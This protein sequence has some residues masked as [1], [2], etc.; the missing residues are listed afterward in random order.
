MYSTSVKYFGHVKRVKYVIHVFQRHA[1]MIPY[2]VKQCMSYPM[3]WCYAMR[4]RR[5]DVTSC[6][7]NVISE[8]DLECSARLSQGPR[9]VT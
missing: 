5:D 2:D 4:W 7:C 3:V 8:S 1:M 9:E 6:Q